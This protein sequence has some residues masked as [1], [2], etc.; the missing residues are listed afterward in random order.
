[1]IP[2]VRIVDQGQHSDLSVLV[3][4]EPQALIFRKNKRAALRAQICGE[5]G[6]TELTA[7]DPGMLYEAYLSSLKAGA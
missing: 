3:A 6:H 1:M 2:D 7:E 4:E 5:C